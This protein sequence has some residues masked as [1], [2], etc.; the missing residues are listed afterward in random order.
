MHP[1]SRTICPL[2]KKTIKIILGMTQMIVGKDIEY[3]VTENIQK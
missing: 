1:K 3:I 2:K